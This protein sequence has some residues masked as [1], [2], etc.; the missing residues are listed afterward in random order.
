MTESYS[1]MLEGCSAM[2]EGCS[3]VA[4]GCSAAIIYFFL[5][6]SGCSNSRFQLRRYSYQASARP[7]MTGRVFI[8][9]R[10]V[11]TPAAAQAFL[12]AELRRVFHVD[13]A[14]GELIVGSSV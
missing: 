8:G 4:E 9:Y 10:P 11:G 12:V 6:I 7:V 13:N 14:C 5:T 1:A 2:L 3:V